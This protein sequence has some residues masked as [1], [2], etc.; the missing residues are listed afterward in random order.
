ML[1]IIFLPNYETNLFSMDTISELTK[2]FLY[3]T[4]IFKIAVEISAINMSLSF[5]EIWYIF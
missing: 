1:K 5:E 2:F 3:F 4:M